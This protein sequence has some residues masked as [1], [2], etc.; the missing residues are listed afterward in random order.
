MIQLSQC[1]LASSSILKFPSLL[2]REGTPLPSTITLRTYY[3]SIL[4]PDLA[5]QADTSLKEDRTALNHWEL[6][7]PNQDIRDIGKEDLYAF[8]DG[9]LTAGLKPPSVNKYWRE[10]KAMLEAARE[11]EIIL[12][13]PA[14]GRRQKCRLVDEGPK[15]QREPLTEAELERLWKAC[16]KATYPRHKQFPAPKLWRVALVLWWTY[17]QRTMDVLKRLRWDSIW[18][19]EKVIRFEAQKTGKLQGLPLTPIVE[20]HLRSIKGHAER[21]FPGFNRAGCYLRAKQKWEPG[22]YATWRREI[23][24]QAGL[25]ELNIKHFRERAVTFYNG[26]EPGL[27]G[28][29]AGHYM[30]GVTAQ[31]YDLPTRRI[32]EAIC[33]APVPACFAEIG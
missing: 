11:D 7:T 25:A 16:S 29:I 6:H 15:R 10:V 18:W 26:I 31:N 17:G 12:R 1:D 33:S 19:S 21:M 8:R 27:G 22:Y 20:Q 32:R 4:L 14:I 5:G 24:G 3:T 23:C 9:M 30:P 28:W 2:E 13:V